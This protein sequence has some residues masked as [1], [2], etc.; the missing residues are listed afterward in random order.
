[1]SWAARFPYSLPENWWPARSAD[2]TLCD[3]SEQSADGAAPGASEQTD[4]AELSHLPSSES[5]VLDVQPTPVYGAESD[6]TSQMSPHSGDPV[7]RAL[8]VACDD[9]FVMPDLAAPPEGPPLTVSLIHLESVNTARCTH[10]GSIGGREPAA[11][12]SKQ[13]HSDASWSSAAAA[14]PLCAATQLPPVFSI[15]HAAASLKVNLAAPN[16]TRAA[17]NDCIDINARPWISAI[18]GMQP[19]PL[20]KSKLATG[21]ANSASSDT[22]AAAPMIAALPP[23][24]APTATAIIAKATAASREPER[25]SG[26]VTAAPLY[27][28]LPPTG[29]SAPPTGVSAPRCPTTGMRGDSPHDS[30]KAAA[31]VRIPIDKRPWI[32]TI[33]GKQPH[34]PAQRVKLVAAVAPRPPAPTIA[35]LP[36]KP[37][38]TAAASVSTASAYTTT[39]TVVS[40]SR[41]T[42]DAYG[43]N[44]PRP[45]P[46]ASAPGP[47]LSTRMPLRVPQQLQKQRQHR[48]R[49][50][51]SSSAGARASANGP[52]PAAGQAALKL[53]SNA[54]RSRASSSTS[55]H[56]RSCD[57]YVSIQLTSDRGEFDDRLVELSRKPVA[58]PVR[59]QSSHHAPRYRRIA[60]Q[61]C[62]PAPAAA[63]TAPTRRADPAIASTD[64]PDTTAGSGNRVLSSR[65]ASPP[66]STCHA[67]SSC[68]PWNVHGCSAN[69]SGKGVVS[70]AESP[71]PIAMHIPPVT[72]P[73]PGPGR[74]W[75]GSEPTQPQLGGV[76][77][78]AVLLPADETSCPRGAAAAAAESRQ[79]STYDSEVYDDFLSQHPVLLALRLAQLGQGAGRQLGLSK[80]SS[81]NDCHWY[82]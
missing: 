26:A 79:Q 66:S 55:R 75:S 46:A 28:S 23:K 63:S 56:G 37:T 27:A 39:T 49:D 68:N 54:R 45:S 38:P 21:A 80:Y 81:D 22:F 64:I 11:S 6:L 35:A 20:H 67:S 60:G 43:Y 3:D 74:G 40:G 10:E 8:G 73:V 12:I 57:A 41:G 33:P 18:A 44:V 9:N 70:S 53:D 62:T 13:P 77:P 32:S 30:S 25:G 58:L 78:A 5:L 19:P 14:A 82:R 76:L 36:P 31:S 7:L 29:I 69:S 2:G 16:N 71:P 72:V 52:A 65:A 50:Q 47:W 61:R 42:I 17:A 59:A 48:Y 24:P 1:M 15:L 34:P 4:A 51:L